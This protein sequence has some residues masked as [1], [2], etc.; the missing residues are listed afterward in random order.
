MLIKEQLM[1]KIFGK[2]EINT[3]VR[4][5]EG[6]KLKQIEK[7]Y[8]YRSIRPKLIAAGILTQNNILREINKDKRKN[9]FFIEY[10]LDSYGYEMFSIKKKRAKKI[11]IEN[12]IIKIL[13]EYPYARFIEAIPIILIKNK[14]NKFKLLELSS[15]YGIK[16]KVGYLIETAIMLKKLDYLED[17]LDYLKNSK[18]KEI[19]LLVEGDYDFLEETSPERIKKWNLL[20]RFFDKDFKKLNEVYL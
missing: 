20:G 16:N 3:I 15:M 11:S 10:N 18:D 12:L 19:S 5:M 7:N 17:F 1:R 13:T 8:L 4:K 14:I 9:I 2:V 6:R